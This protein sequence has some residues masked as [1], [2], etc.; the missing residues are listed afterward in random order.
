MS[1]CC[2]VTCTAS[3]A[4]PASAS[5]AFGS[6]EVPRVARATALY[7]FSAFEYAVVSLEKASVAFVRSSCVSGSAPSAWPSVEL[8]SRPGGV[9][10]LE[11]SASCEL[12]A[13]LKRPDEKWV[14]ERAYERPRFVED[15]VREVGTRLRRDRSF[16]RWEV[17]AESLESI[18]AHSAYA[19]LSYPGP[20]NG[21]I[22]GES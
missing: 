3:T 16:P 2:P 13:L 21:R 15:L 22:A 5:C 9:T 8:M 14:T 17:E 18:H 10:D 1:V 6:C 4:T 7:A 11:E 20:S 12:Y 19:R